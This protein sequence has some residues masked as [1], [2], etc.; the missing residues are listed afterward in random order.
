MIDPWALI[1]QM[2]HHLA[3]QII[4]NGINGIPF[5]ATCEML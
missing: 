5:R 3:L 4:T 1:T 2:L